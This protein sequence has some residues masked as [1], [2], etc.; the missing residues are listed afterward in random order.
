MLNQ[1]TQ[2]AGQL[3]AFRCDASNTIGT[4]HV[5]RCLTLADALKQK[6]AT[7]LFVCR[8]AKGNIIEHIKAQGFAVHP[9]PENVNVEQDWQQ[10]V[11]FLKTLK[12]PP[13]WLVVDHYHLDATWEGHL[14]P[15]VNHILVIDDMANRPHMCDVLLDQ[16]MVPDMSHRYTGLLKGKS[17]ELLGPKYALLRPEFVEARKQVTK[18]TFPP[19]H[20]LVNFGGGDHKSM[21]LM[22]LRALNYMGYPGGV[23]LVAGGNNPDMDELEALCAKRPNTTFY[24][25]TDNMAELMRRA[26]I[27]IGAGGATTWERMC[28]GLPCVTVAIADNQVEIAKFLGENHYTFYAGL[29]DE[30]TPQSLATYLEEVF[31]DEEK[32][33]GIEQYAMGHVDGQGAPTL[34]HILLDKD[35]E[36]FKK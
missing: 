25:T 22:S 29:A 32:F 15:Y 20:V 31:F 14:R 19:K 8:A 17:I 24:K 26:D 27:A 30:L 21:C 28:M 36:V 1:Q 34:A 13:Y 35:S 4:G 3:I 11:A 7:C 12:H 5:M 18:R 16:N 6:G 2:Q 9:L 33:R 23:T 10:T